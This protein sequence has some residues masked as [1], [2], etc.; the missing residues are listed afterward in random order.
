MNG[1]PPTKPSRVLITGGRAPAALGLARLFWRSGHHVVMAES[2]HRHI[3]QGSRAVRRHYRVPRPVDGLAEYTA[4]LVRIVRAEHIELL[5]PANEETL[6]VARCREKL[7]GY[8]SVFTDHFHTLD[9]LHN[10]WSF[11]RLIEGLGLAVPRT[12]LATSPDELVS[13]LRSSHN[14]VLKPAY[15]RFGSDVVVRPRLSARLPADV[16]PTR[17]W[18]VQEYVEGVQ[19][20]TYGVARAGRLLAHAAY[21]TRFTVGPGTNIH[22]RAVHD[23]DLT[24][25][26]AGVVGRLGFTGQIAFDLIRAR[27]GRLL[28]IECNPRATN[29]TLLFRPA[30]G[31]P[32]AFLGSPAR[33]TE[34]SRGRETMLG[35][36]M[37]FYGWKALRTR[38]VGKW[39]R[40]LW[41]ADGA[42]YDLHDPMPAASQYLCVLYLWA[43][44]IRLGLSFTEASMADIEWNGEVVGPELANVAKTV[45]M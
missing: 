27:D 21:D 29:G 5:V 2:A 15:S 10:K 1:V 9:R 14:V 41:R 31:L 25:W 18:L 20:C 13:A 42:V 3:S 44:S 43:D 24:S 17:P 37:M 30:D 6:Y 16:S 39:L 38:T 4:A 40:A 11:N 7:S 32:A 26:V 34:P 12:T 45:T 35:V 8:C 23:P 28:P 19:L 36:P 22:F 33:M